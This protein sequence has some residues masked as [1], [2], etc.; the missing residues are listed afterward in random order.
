ME[1]LTSELD[2][3]DMIALSEM[4]RQWAVYEAGLTPERRTR[5]IKY[6]AD[7]E[8]IAEWVGPRWKAT[9]RPAKPP[10]LAV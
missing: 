9:D 6:S 7:L 8:R 1:A 5:M 2:Y 4:C 3:A 10:L